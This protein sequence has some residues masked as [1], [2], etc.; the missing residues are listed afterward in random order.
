MKIRTIDKGYDEYR[1]T[2]DPYTCMSRHSWR[3]IVVA[4]KL[5][6]SR[7]SGSRWLYD[8]DEMVQYLQNPPV[9]VE[10]APASTY[11]MLRRVGG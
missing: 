3:Q 5:R 11:G 4:K 8:L 10:A 2:V 1:S 9:E 7:Q 6:S